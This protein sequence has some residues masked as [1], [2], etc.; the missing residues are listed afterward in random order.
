MPTSVAILRVIHILN[1]V[2]MAWPIYALVMVNQR[3]RLGPPLGDRVDIFMENTIK[4]RT[5]PCLI[6]QLTALVS[7]L[8]LIL[9]SNQSLSVI[10]SNTALAVKFGL[11]LVV[12]GLLAMVHF[13]LQPRIDSLF[14]SGQPPLCI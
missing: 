1:A 10:F 2:L 9:A 7:G 11:L 3:L 14:A 13:N 5:I 6:F 12:M 8:A 4:N